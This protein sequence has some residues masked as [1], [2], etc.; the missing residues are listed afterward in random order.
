MCYLASD[1]L[2]LILGGSNY[3]D[4]QELL[5]TIFYIFCGY[6]L[7]LPLDRFTGVLLDSIN[8]PQLNLYKVIFMASANIIVDVIAVFYFESLVVV[9]IG[10]VGFTV[11][12]IIMGF[13]F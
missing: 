6:L 9:A 2:I 10:T 1:L 3:A 5:N 13:Y 4:S 11:I 12:G 8:K 7:L